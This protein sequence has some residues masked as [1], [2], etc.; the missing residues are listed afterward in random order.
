MDI[1]SKITS[2][3]K[4]NGMKYLC[5]NLGIAGCGGR[6]R[7]PISQALKT[8]IK[9]NIDGLRNIINIYDKM[10]TEYFLSGKSK[11]K[12]TLPRSTTQIQQSHD[13]APIKPYQNV[14][15]TKPYQN[16]VQ[17][18]PYQNFSQI[19]P[20][21]NV[22]QIKPH[23]NVVQT[24][25]NQNVAQ[26]KPHQNVVQIKPYHG[27]IVSIKPHQNVVQIKPHH[28]V[29]QT[30]PYHG[31]IVS[32]KPYIQ[33]KQ[34]SSNLNSENILNKQTSQINVDVPNK[35]KNKQTL[36]LDDKNVFNRLNDIRKQKI[37]LINQKAMFQKIQVG[38][39]NSSALLTK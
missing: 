21:Q 22:V 31:N 14:I 10:S 19:K 25:P 39:S 18:K 37:N 29:V 38:S 27:N 26:I 12:I 28:N 35:I 9:N 16:V 20:H 11:I 5:D 15:Q 24:K 4:V 1:L 30:E 2:T 23:Q 13:I 8:Y 3:L 17:T 34:T 36:P 32:I 7:D 33:N 6:T